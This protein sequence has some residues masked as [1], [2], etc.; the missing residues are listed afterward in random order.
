VIYS[1]GVLG[2]ARISINYIK[3]NIK[4]R[5]RLRCY[6]IDILQVFVS[7]AYLSASRSNTTRS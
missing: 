4:A 6:L 3:D 1:R 2:A 7:K 5:K